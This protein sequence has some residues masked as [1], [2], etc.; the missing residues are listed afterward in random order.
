MGK[1]FLFLAPAAALGFGA[2]LGGASGASATEGITDGAALRTCLQSTVQETCSLGGDV[3]LDATSHT[4]H[5][6]STY[7]WYTDLSVEIK[8]GHSVKL[9]LNGH[10]LTA[11]IPINIGKGNL[12]VVNGSETEGAIN[13]T[14]N[15]THLRTNEGGTPQYTDIKPQFTLAGSSNSNDAN[16]SVL[17]L[18]NNIAVSNVDNETI[19]M[20]SDA[21]SADHFHGMVANINGTKITTPKAININARPAGTHD[22]TKGIPAINISNA[23]INTTN[24]TFTVDEDSIWNVKD[25]TVESESDVFKMSKGTVSISVEGDGTKISSTGN[26]D[27]IFDVNQFDYSQV[28]IEISDG[29]FQSADA[30]YRETFSAANRQT[31]KLAINGGTFTANDL[32]DV[33]DAGRSYPSFIETHKGFI[34]GGTWGSE[35]DENDNVFVASGYLKDFDESLGEFSNVM[36]V[37]KPSVED[38]PEGWTIDLSRRVINDTEVLKYILEKAGVQGIAL[39]QYLEAYLFDATG[40]QQSELPDGSEGITLRIS[41]FDGIPEKQDGATRKYYIVSMHYNEGG[42]PEIYATETTYDEETG[43]VV[44]PNLTKFSNFFIAYA[45]TVNPTPEEET[46]PTSPESGF[47]TKKAL[48]RAA[49][50]TTSLLAIVLSGLSIAAFAGMKFFGKKQ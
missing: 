16:Y 47:L 32:F 24:E 46:A 33:Y 14:A 35:W 1:K 40:V 9:D 41:G 34:K 3:T 26:D 31:S 6:S 17:S 37:T 43:E 21:G 7:N 29:V 39:N 22:Y 2:I 27:A 23:T 28:S 50:G 12:N 38:L 10:K 44:L 8:N 19:L 20:D 5:G 30:F 48:E 25:T 18:G 11:N 36:T 13:F 15:R 42:E 49:T 4:H 45:D